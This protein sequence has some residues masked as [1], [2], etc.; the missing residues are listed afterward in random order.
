MKVFSRAF[1]LR[2][3]VLLM[4]LCLLL[5]GVFYVQCVD[6]PVR[7]GIAAAEEERASLETELMVVEAKLARMDKMEHEMGRYAAQGQI[8]IMGSYNNSKA[9]VKMLNDILEKANTYA[10]TFT[11]VTRDGDQV[12]RNFTLR[13]TA[14]NYETAAQIIAQLS[15]GQYRCLLGN[16]VC[17]SDSNYHNLERG[18][19]IVNLSAT[20]FET[21]VGGTVDAGLPVKS[22]KV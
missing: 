7:E 6:M 2:E 3:K 13:F 4:V 22:T 14:K 16:V 18:A 12:R 1:T 19:V 15:N 10:I 9:E 20:F 8:G 21:M 5:L 17:E 11:D